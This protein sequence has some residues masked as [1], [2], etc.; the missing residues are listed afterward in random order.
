MHH[1]E[2]LD[3]WGFGHKNHDLLK[4]IVYFKLS[5]VLLNPIVKVTTRTVDLECH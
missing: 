3:L 1:M 2:G 5:H 4:M